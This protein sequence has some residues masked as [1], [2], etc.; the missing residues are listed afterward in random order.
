MSGSLAELAR[1]AVE[2]LEAIVGGDPNSSDRL[3]LVADLVRTLLP[4][5]ERLGVATAADIDCETLVE[6]MRNEAIAS[7]GVIVGRSEIGAWPRV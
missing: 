7:A 5:M 1:R 3:H 6:R 2:R 4:E